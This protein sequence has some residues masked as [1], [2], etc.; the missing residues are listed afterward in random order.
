MPETLAFSAVMAIHSL[1]LAARAA[2]L[3][4]GWVSILNPETMGEILDTP[5]DWDFI[6]YLCL[7]YPAANSDVPELEIEGWERR[8]PMK[9]LQR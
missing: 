3:G 7:G 4:L 2:G 5:E 8:Q 9:L 6:A 1:W